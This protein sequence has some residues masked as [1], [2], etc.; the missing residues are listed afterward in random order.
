MI[1]IIKKT[2]AEFAALAD[3]PPCPSVMVDDRFIAKGS[4]VTY[5][6]LKKAI[7]SEN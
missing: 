3:Q 5:E 1:V 2:S 6:E 7:L 4:L